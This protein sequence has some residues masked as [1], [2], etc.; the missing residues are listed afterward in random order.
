MRTHLDC[1][2][3][4]VRQALD[5]VQQV[6]RDAS[7]QEKVVRDVLRAAA[8]MDYS[9]SPPAM[10]QLIHRL[11]R[12]ATGNSDPYREVKERFNRFALNLY[13]GLHRRV[14]EAD[15][16]LGAAL[17]LAAAGN[18]IDLGVKS[19]IKE[20][21]VRCVIEE[22]LNAPLDPRAVSE[23]RRAAASARRILY[24]G[25]NAGEIVLD[26]L[27]V[28]QLGPPKVTFSVRGAPVINDATIADAQASGMAD[29][30]EITDSGSDAPGTILED[31]SEAFRK[32]FTEAD[33]VLAK[34]QGNYETLSGAGRRVFFLLRA[35]CPVLARDIGCPMG[36]LVLTEGRNSPSSATRAKAAEPALS[37]P[38]ASPREGL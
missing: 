10:G 32:L 14:R 13:A 3:C 18:V 9:M 35:K 25:D 17:R 5:S 8:A 11:I 19:G 36:S 21:E 1:I 24:I 7:D 23:L 29:I 28:E 16:P 34:G 4:L 37:R 30:V 27:L 6:T 15:D 12:E 20:A 31:C 2:P 22:S 38:A 26:R 33:L